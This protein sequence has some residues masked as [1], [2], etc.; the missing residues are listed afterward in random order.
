M[1]RSNQLSVEII[2]NENT[3]AR[4]QINVNKDC[5]CHTGLAKDHGGHLANQ[6]RL[7]LIEK[8]KC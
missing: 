4:E 3:M 1:Q 7:K 2:I 8:D 6:P 5:T